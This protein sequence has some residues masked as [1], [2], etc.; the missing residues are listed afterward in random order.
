MDSWV[1]TELLVAEEDGAGQSAGSVSEAA[2]VTDS[3]AVTESDGRM[4]T[5]SDGRV[6]AAS[7]ASEPADGS[8]QGIEASACPAPKRSRN[9]SLMT[10]PMKILSVI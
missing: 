7:D 9:V 1:N 4:V 6:D 10:T 8:G 2:G 5:N 3:R